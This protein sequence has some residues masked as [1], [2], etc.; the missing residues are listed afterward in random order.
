MCKGLESLAFG[1]LPT[2]TSQK[3]PHIIDVSS[4]ASKVSKVSEVHVLHVRSL[5]L[6]VLW[7]TNFL[8]S[9]ILQVVYPGLIENYNFW[10][11][12]LKM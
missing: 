11:E 6:H 2:P 8:S 5:E 1:I 4:H 7:A 12:V 9:S 3:L 10:Q